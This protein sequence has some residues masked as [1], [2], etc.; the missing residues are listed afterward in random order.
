[1]FK[2]LVVEWKRLTNKERN[3]EKEESCTWRPGHDWN[4]S[5][6]NENICNLVFKQ[7]P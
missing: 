4:F 6:K 7:K 5:E 2:C 3:A 1:M